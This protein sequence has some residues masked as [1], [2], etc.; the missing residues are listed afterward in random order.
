MKTSRQLLGIL[1]AV[2]LVVVL[3][4]GEPAVAADGHPAMLRVFHAAPDAPELDVIVDGVGRVSTGVR[5]GH[6]SHRASIPAGFH[7]VRVVPAGASAAASMTDVEVNVLYDRRYMLVLSE[8]DGRHE[9]LPLELPVGC[10]TTPRRTQI[11]VLQ[12]APLGMA[13]DLKVQGGPYLFRGLEYGKVSECLLL[14]AGDYHLEV[15]ES[16]FTW[17]VGAVD[18]RAELGAGNAYVLV[19]GPARQAPDR[20]VRIWAIPML[21]GG[22]GLGQPSR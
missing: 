21:G 13:I 7:T 22:H 3:A 2:L 12:A 18:E 8:L 16:G 20:L 5:Y 17:N 4:P 15:L 1:A 9:L 19:I 6:L 11:R 14:P 10:P